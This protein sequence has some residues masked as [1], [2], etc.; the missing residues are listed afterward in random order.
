MKR[1]LFASSTLAITAITLLSGCVE[2][3]TVY[4]QGPPPGAPAAPG[5]VVVNEAPPVPPQEV[6]VAAP[7]PEYVWAPGYYSWNG[8]WVWVRGSWVIRP[9]PGAVWVGG[10]WGRRGHGYVWVGGHWR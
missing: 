4:V 9:H 1:L 6:I 8:G 2:R 10:R 7:G 3:R 5:E